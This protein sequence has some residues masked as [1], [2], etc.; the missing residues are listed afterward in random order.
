MHTEDG[1]RKDG[2]GPSAA[3]PTF[4]LLSVRGW[5]GRRSRRRHGGHCL[6]LTERAPDAVPF[7]SKAFGQQEGIGRS[8]VPAH[9]VADEY[10]R[11]SSAESTPLCLFMFRITCKLE[12]PQTNDLLQRFA[13][14][15]VVLVGC[16]QYGI[17]L[18]QGDRVVQGVKHMLAEG[19]GKIAGPLIDLYAVRHG[20]LQS[21]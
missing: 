19:G 7:S 3:C 21:V 17:R 2:T 13:L 18:C 16:Y 14:P 9:H 12:V 4:L 15:I 20:E 5:N 1:S 11:R 8:L 10:L 6:S